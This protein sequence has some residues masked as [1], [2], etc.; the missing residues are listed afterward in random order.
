[1]EVIS[2]AYFRII[3]TLD[4]RGSDK[5]PITRTY[6]YQQSQQRNC[7]IC[8]VSPSVFRWPMEVQ[9]SNRDT[10][11][12]KG[13]SCNSGGYSRPVS[14]VYTYHMIGTFLVTN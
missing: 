10:F 14:D 8:F 6:R 3:M 7:V 11:S 5:K 1:M 2:K 9:G 12:L 4:R 13:L